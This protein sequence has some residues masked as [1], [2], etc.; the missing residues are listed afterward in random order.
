MSY[1]IINYI[2]TIAA[3]ILLGALIIPRI[4]VIAYRRNLYDVADG[5]K[6]HAGR[7]PR[8]GGMSFLPSIGIALTLVIGINMRYY[9][10]HMWDMFSQE[11]VPLLFLTGALLMIYLMGITDDLVGVK[12]RAKFFFQIVAGALLV[13]SG[14]RI[15]DL[16][17]FLWIEEIAPWVSCVIVIFFTV[18]VLNAINLIDGIDGLASGLSIV[19][20]GWYSYLFYQSG[21]HVSLLIS[22]AAMGTLIPFFIFNVFG[23][24]SARTKIFMGDTG[25]LTMGLLLVYL[26]IKVADLPAGTLGDENLFVLAVAPILIPCFDVVRVFLHRVKKGRNPFLPDKVHIHHK[27]LATGMKQNM[28]MVVILLGDAVMILLNLWCSAF[29]GATWIILGDILIWTVLNIGLTS[30]IRSRE[31]RL[32]T[33]LFD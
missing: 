28:A 10:S 9:G 7:V 25:S 23:K 19:A 2:M 24:A 26:S 16:Y 13:V 21:E 22:G 29:V 5:R 20:F 14:L 17:G 27:L 15:P 1:W 6:I 3:A 32:D 4:L 11:G 12:Y 33:N 31:R 8:L 18:Y 30:A